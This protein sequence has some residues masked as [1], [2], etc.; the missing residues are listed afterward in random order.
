M[1]RLTKQVVDAAKPKATAFFVW[2][3]DLERNPIILYRAHN[4]RI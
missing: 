4:H 1:T 2:C 3:G